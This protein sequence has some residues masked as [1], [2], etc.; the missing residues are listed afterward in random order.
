MVLK[1]VCAVRMVPRESV[2]ANETFDSYLKITFFFKLFKFQFLTGL[3]K[4]HGK[5]STAASFSEACSC[6]ANVCQ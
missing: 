5:Q 6:K 3:S 4:L 2:A 1:A